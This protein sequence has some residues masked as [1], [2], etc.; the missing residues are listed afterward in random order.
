MKKSIVLIFSVLVF[1]SLF[2]QTSFQI[3]I[4][5]GNIQYSNLP[6][7]AVVFVT[8]EPFVRIVVNGKYIGTTD[9]FGRLVFVFKE[10]GFYEAWVDTGEMI[11]QRV[12]FFV[13]KRTTY[14]YMPIVKFTRLT[15][16][17]NVYPV[18][19]YFDRYLLGVATQGAP[20]VNVPQGNVELTFHAKAY[21]SILRSVQTSGADTPIWLEFEPEKFNFE[22]I[23][24]PKSFSPNSDWYE[25]MT[26]FRMYLST[27]A[28]LRLQII[29]KSGKI[30]LE[31]SIEGK[32]GTNVF[33]WDGSK[34]PDGEYS[35][36]VIA[37]NGRETIERIQ[38][39][40]ID[41]SVYTY[42]KEIT[43]AILAIF[44]GLVIYL[45][46]TQK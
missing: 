13:T 21:K 9:V 17:S 37:D 22:L 43:L 44:T 33:E 45:I 6:D 41:T 24:E 29:D 34:L 8:S 23:V 1:S 32:P 31:K 12:S 38:N 26:Q 10:E 5:F 35:V 7:Y 2:S 40:I 3:T 4:S 28:I 20:F 36:K 42:R 16:F 25:D 18:H 30:L 27:F 19:V 14:V 39:V 46:A 11:T 15:V